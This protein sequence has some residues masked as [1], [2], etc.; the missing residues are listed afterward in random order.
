MPK[1][2]Y[3]VLPISSRQLQPVFFFF[4]QYNHYK[5]AIMYFHQQWNFAVSCFYRVI[6]SG[7]HSDKTDIVHQWPIILINLYLP[8][9]TLLCASRDRVVS[10]RASRKI[11]LSIIYIYCYYLLNFYCPLQIEFPCESISS[12]PNDRSHLQWH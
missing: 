4:S 8:Y 3:K 9:N 5:Q 10:E 12:W 6:F 11:S 1:L 2:L 7:S